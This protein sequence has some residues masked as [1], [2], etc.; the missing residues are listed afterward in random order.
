MRHIPSFLMMM[1]LPMSLAHADVRSDLQSGLSVENIIAQ[2]EP[3]CSNLLE[4][5]GQIIDLAPDHAYNAVAAAAAVGSKTCDVGGYA[6]SKGLDR[7]MIN[8]LIAAVRVSTRSNASSNLTLRLGFPVT[9]VKSA[10]GGRILI[11]QSCGG[12]YIAVG[13]ICSVSRH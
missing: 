10:S 6:I 9:R 12:T 4:I 1:L 5:V 13:G 11:N 3:T 7:Q 8:Q 2:I